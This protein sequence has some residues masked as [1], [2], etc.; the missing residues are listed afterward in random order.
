MSNTKFNILGTP[1]L[2]KYE[3]SKKF[4]SHTLGINQN[5]DKKS[6]KFYESSIKPPPYY[7]RIFPIFGDQSI[8]FSPFEHRVLTYS[9][10]AYECK[11]KKASGTILYL[12]DFS[13][14]PLR[15]SMFFSIMDINNFEYSYQSFIQILIHN[16]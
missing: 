14:V 6:L 9:L 4:S 7:S 10:T 16:P 11:N 12:S 3:D 5:N 13:F 15:K 1:F 8:F 2:E